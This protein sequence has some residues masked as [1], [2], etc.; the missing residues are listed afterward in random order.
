[1]YSYIF[2]HTVA[3]QLGFKLQLYLIW[4]FSR[5]KFSFPTN[6][7]LFSQSISLHPYRVY[8][9]KKGYG[10]GNYIMCYSWLR[11][12]FCGWNTD[13]PAAVA[14]STKHR[15]RVYILKGVDGAYR[16]Q[17]HLIIVMSIRNSYPILPI[18]FWSQVK[19]LPNANAKYYQTH[20]GLLDG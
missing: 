14:I 19:E 5:K 16:L 7:S 11:M 8:I 3:E 9:L 6:C 15:S 4:D 10:F 12:C 20:P 17:I 1:M 18:F 13:S 2:A